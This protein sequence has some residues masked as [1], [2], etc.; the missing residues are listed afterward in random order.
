VD[1][2]KNLLMTRLEDLEAEV[3]SL[4]EKDEASEDS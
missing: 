4:R 3:R 2:E 1:E